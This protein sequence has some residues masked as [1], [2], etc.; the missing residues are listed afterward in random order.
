M[1]TRKENDLLT[2]VTGDAPMRQL[3]IQHWTPVCLIEEV[4]EPDGA[5]L[6]VECLGEKY[7]AFRDSMGRVGLLDELCPHRKASLVYGRNEECG[8]RCLYHGWKFDVE[9]KVLAMSSE[10]EGSPLMNKVSARAYPVNEWGGFVWAWLGKAENAPAFDPPAFAPANDIPIAI[11]KIRVPA[12]WAQIHEGQIDSAHSSSLHSSDMKPA[13]VE[14]AAADDRAWY[15]P[16][17]DKSPRMQ[18]ET[19]SYGFH[20]AAIRRPIKNAQTHNYLRI[21]EFVAPYYSLIPPNNNYN[22]ASV[23]VPIN[24]EETAF[25]FIAWG[26][27]N[28]PSTEDWRHFNHAVPGEDLDELWRPNRRDDNNF[29]QDRDLMKEGN[30]TGI[31]GIPNQDIA[32]WVSMGAR[33]ERH[34]DTLGASDLAIVE[35]RRLMVD[36]ASKIAEGGR[37]IGTEE[38]RLPQAQI[39]SREG[40]YP[41]E[42][43]WRD[44][45]R[46]GRAAA[47]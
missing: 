15:R 3:M 5:P 6:R 31:R 42:T 12:N 25:H 13:R 29:L 18:T 21:T 32:M 36:A 10:P 46:H 22:V 33:V 38:P 35:F 43:D 23:I 44:L 17:T 40:V 8:L 2:L 27:R 11:L 34:S 37:A 28:T 9:G 14:G 20:Y 39:A 19:T 1:L 16:S 30:F 7:V 45:T 24:D 41:K 4:A 47:E 26:D